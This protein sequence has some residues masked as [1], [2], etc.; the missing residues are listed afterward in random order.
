MQGTRP[1]D[2]STSYS[3]SNR[4]FSS[5]P[6]RTSSR[7]RNVM[8]ACTPVVA[9][10]VPSSHRR[11]DTAYRLYQVSRDTE[12]CVSS[13][14]AR[15]KPLPSTPPVHYV[16]PSDSGNLKLLCHVPSVFQKTGESWLETKLGPRITA[17][18]RHAVLR[19][20]D[21]ENRHG[22]RRPC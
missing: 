21:S 9:W 7:G 8:G 17:E 5:C 20:A 2:G 6:E 10:L 3:P 18:H 11:V 15:N 13:I 4:A 12:L 22:A 14:C 16:Q 19:D 1:A